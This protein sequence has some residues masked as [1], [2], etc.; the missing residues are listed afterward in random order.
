MVFEDSLV[1]V[2]ALGVVCTS[3]YAE[4]RIYTSI[5][6]I[7]CSD[8]YEDVLE[9]HPSLPGGLYFK[10]GTIYGYA[11][12][13]CELTAFSVSSVTGR[14]HTSVIHLGGMSYLM[15]LS[16]V[17]APL[18]V[19]Y[20]DNP[21]LYIIRDVSLSGLKIHSNAMYSHVYVNQLPS[22]LVIDDT[23][24]MIVGTY[25]GNYSGIFNST[26]QICNGFGCLSRVFSFILSC[27][28]FLSVLNE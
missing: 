1:V 15:L 18:T 23:R 21:E 14:S 27:I 7:S 3:Y 24:R 4:V 25:D 9:I 2:S 8:R 6:P 20:I 28:S 16:L 11:S 17:E 5:T 22:G 26:F 12:E 10:N 19:L 13:S